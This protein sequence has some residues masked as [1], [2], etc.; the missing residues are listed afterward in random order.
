MKYL[1]TYKRKT[2]IFDIILDQSIINNNH[3]TIKN[4]HDKQ[5]RCSGAHLQQFSETLSQN[6]NFI[7]ASNIA[8]W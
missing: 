4:M 6:K 3:K 5:T 7:R 8:Q 2:K 1:G